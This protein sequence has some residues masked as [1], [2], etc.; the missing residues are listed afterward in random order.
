[1]IRNVVMSGIEC[2]DDDADDYKVDVSQGAG[3]D[4]YVSASKLCY[5]VI[6]HVIQSVTIAS[7]LD[8]IVNCC[9]SDHSKIIVFV[10]SVLEFALSVKI[11]VSVHKETYA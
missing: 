5:S 3:S 1:M 9:P 2:D 8:Y 6:M 11:S 10:I 4:P 7:L